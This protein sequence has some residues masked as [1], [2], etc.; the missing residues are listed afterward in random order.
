MKNIGIVGAT[1]AVGKEVLGVLEKRNFPV[2][3]LKLFATAQNAGKKVEF[4]G[5]EY[6]IEEMGDDFYKGLDILIFVAGGSISQKYAPIAAAN[7][8]VVIDNSS[9]F[10]MDPTVPL[11]VPEVNPEDVKNNKGIIANPNCSTIQMCVALWPIHKKYGIKRIIMSTYQASSGAGKNGMDELLKQT[12]AYVEGQDM[13][14]KYFPHQLMF[15]VIPQID[16]FTENDYT[17]EEMKVVNETKKIFH[18]DSIKISVT[19]VRVPV[20]R[21][22]SEAVT[23]ELEN[24]ASPLEIKELLKNSEGVVVQDDINN[25][26]Y[27]MPYFTATKYETFVGRIRKD[28]AFDNGISMWVVADQILKGA[29]LNAVQIAELL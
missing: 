5:K 10:R 13:E 12:N 24:Y 6:T 2:G 7:G 19:A 27:P 8:V 28:L 3:D 23:I 20:L 16:V 15:N 26:V 22:H 21:A 25:K 29:A 4:K 17:K 9:A 11:V 1:G 18:D 14:V